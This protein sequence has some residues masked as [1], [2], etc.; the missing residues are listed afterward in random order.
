MRNSNTGTIRSLEQPEDYGFFGPDSVTWKVFL[1]PTSFSVGFQR[2]VVTEMFEPF[3]MASVSDT[4]AVMNRPSLRYDRTMQYVS[5]VAFADS[6]K[7]VK[8]SEILYRIH[9]K[10]VGEEPI[11]KKLYDANNPDSQLWI[12]LTQWHSVLYT[13]ELFGPG[14]LS[15]KED[16][17]YWADCRTA[18]AFQTID[19]ES[20][21]RN[22]AEVKRYFDEMKPKL[23]S[24]VV[25]QE[26]VEHLLGSANF[27]LENMPAPVKPFKPFI[28][29]LFRKTTIAT[30]PKWMRK[31]GGIQ[32]NPVEDAAVLVLMK[33]F[34]F[35]FARVPKREQLKIL[36]RVSPGAAEVMAP[37]FLNKKPLK[38]EVLSP[39]R[40]W[41]ESG[42]KSPRE[43]ILERGEPVAS[44]GRRAATD[45]G[46]ETLL[47][48]A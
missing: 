29:Y 33:M 36:S 46:A 19:P 22:R 3:L 26:T 42:L 8:A 6:K 18:A 31:M 44:Q 4:Q 28:N 43:S 17:Q 20:V 5:T 35:G 32:Q 45:G 12:H 40:A 1:Y 30:L 27:L 37:V 14:Q 21:P 10:I 15:K 39:D 24:R 23:A 25:T 16:E 38:E 47:Q 9:D 34:Y 7:V 11:S 13:Y 48:F 2:T 41:K